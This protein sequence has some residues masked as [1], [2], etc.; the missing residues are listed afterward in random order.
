MRDIDIRAELKSTILRDYFSDNKSK[1]VD[2]L[3]LCYGD[4]R[5]D[6]AVINGAL[7]GF[8]I[9]SER[10]NLRRLPSQVE[11]YLRVLDFLTI[12]TCK[13]HINGVL[14]LV[15]DQ[16]GLIVAEPGNNKEDINFSIIREPLKNELVEKASLVQLLWRDELLALIG[17]R[18]ERGYL[19][20]PKRAL[21][22]IACALYS[23]Q[24]LS[25]YVRNALKVRV[26]WKS[27]PPLHPLKTPL[28]NKNGKLW[29]CPLP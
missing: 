23:M 26:N 24:E 19:S 29:G 16:C 6:V 13:N 1:V 4:S 25:E 7:L 20:K 14:D 17:Q 15:P 8:E 9:K 28:R 12:I 11:S 27:D 18:R 21:W 22:D 5:I 10:D 2:E 3:E